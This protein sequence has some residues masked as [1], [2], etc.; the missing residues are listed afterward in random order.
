MN[1]LKDWMKLA[2]A[3]EK[4]VLAKKAGTS[5]AYL[6][7]IAMGRRHC[8]IELS[9]EIE[10]ATAVLP[11]FIARKLPVVYK[12]TLNKKWKRFK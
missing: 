3:K 4:E 11:A 9:F 5:V 12:E 6:R 1:T 8:G 10:K 7:H 2:T